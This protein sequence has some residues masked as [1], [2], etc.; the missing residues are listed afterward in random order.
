LGVEVIQISE[1][2]SSPK[3]KKKLRTQLNENFNDISSADE[4]KKTTI[5]HL[6]KNYK[7][8]IHLFGDRKQMFYLFLNVIMQV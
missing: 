2:K 3:R 6:F 4:N 5:E 7:K 1:A 8:A